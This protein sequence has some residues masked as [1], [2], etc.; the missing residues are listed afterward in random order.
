MKFENEVINLIHDND[1]VFGNLLLKSLLGGVEFNVTAT[2]PQ[3][4]GN[5]TPSFKILVLDSVVVLKNVEDCW[6]VVSSS[7]DTPS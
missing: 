1:I 4:L 3:S 2:S 6:L 5:L 7:P